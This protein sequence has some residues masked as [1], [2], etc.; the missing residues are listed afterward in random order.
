M[1]FRHYNH[2]MIAT[3]CIRM[4]NNLLSNYYDSRIVQNCSCRRKCISDH[5]KNTSIAIATRNHLSHGI[6]FHNYMARRVIL[7][8]H[9]DLDRRVVAALWAI[10]PRSCRRAADDREF[11]QPPPVS[12]RK[13]PRRSAVM[14]KTRRTARISLAQLPW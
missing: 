2:N 11:R 9:H 8:G 1:Y 3:S 12:D 7:A 10:R 4:D 13:R 5:A 14:A 6:L